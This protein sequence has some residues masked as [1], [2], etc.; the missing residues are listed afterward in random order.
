MGIAF[1]PGGLAEIVRAARARTG[2]PGVAAGLLS[3][4]WLEL[5][6]D[7]ELELGRGEPVTSETPFRIASVS[8]MFTA[9]LAVSCLDLDEPVLG[10][11]SAR[12]LLS[13]TAGLRQ[14][15]AEPL[16]EPASGLWSYSNAGYWAVGEACARACGDSFASAMR[17]RILDPLGL[18][19]TGY[20]EPAQPARGHVQEGETGHLPVPVDVYPVERYPSGGIWSTVGDL[21]RFA[22]H[23]LGGPGPL[24]E[25]DRAALRQPQAEALGGAYALG[26][27]VRELEGGRIAL[28]HEGSVGGYQTLLLLVPEER[29][30][31]AVLTNSWRGSGLIRRVVQALGLV[32]STGLPHGEERPGEEL[33]GHYALDSSEAHVEQGPDGLRVREFEV[34]PVTGA[35][36]ASP[37]YPATRLG[38]DLFGLAGGL[39][40]THRVDFPRPGVARVGWIALPR[41]E[42]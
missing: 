10:V 32:P 29:L 1:P 4:G 42:S 3:D 19:D 22:E 17:A 28:D 11:A 18:G 14:E 5:A 39:L 40:M 36:L 9:S 15:S 25:A 26:L 2:V 27:W 13:H 33:V 38:G 24:G 31:L 37:A 21:L 8:K 16:P 6:A 41:A 12:A 35:S 23:Q 34:D 30:A 7:G 20:E